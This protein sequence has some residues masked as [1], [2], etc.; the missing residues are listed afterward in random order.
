MPSTMTGIRPV[1]CCTRSVKMS[2]LRAAR[3]ALVAI[4][5]M[6]ASLISQ[7]RR[8][9][10]KFLITEMHSRKDSLETCPVV[11]TSL[12]S[13]TG[14][15]VLSSACQRPSGKISATNNLI[16]VEPISSTAAKRFLFSIGALIAYRSA[17]SIFPM[18]WAG[19]SSFSPIYLS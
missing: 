2:R 11:K 19:F 16:P 18:E 14:L 15:P 8:N 3:R 5:R 1:S 12:P 9:S 10:R 7:L 17:S 13:A 6:S 4:T